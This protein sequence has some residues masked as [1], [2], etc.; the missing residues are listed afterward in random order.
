[1]QTPVAVGSPSEDN[2]QLVQAC[3]VGARTLIR[4]EAMMVGQLAE[5][6]SIFYVYV[7]LEL[8]GGQYTNSRLISGR[9]T[10]V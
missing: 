5:D 1:M 7:V 8:A 4:P 6:L 10:I 9:L 3:A 2:T